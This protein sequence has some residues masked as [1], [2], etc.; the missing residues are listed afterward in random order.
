M[1]GIFHINGGFSFLW[2]GMNPKGNNFD[3]LKTILNEDLV[4]VTTCVILPIVYHYNLL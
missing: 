2:I 1:M 3:Y 4:T